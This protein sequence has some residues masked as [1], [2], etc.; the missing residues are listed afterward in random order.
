LSSDKTSGKGIIG[1]TLNG[2]TKKIDLN[3]TLQNG[4][5]LDAKTNLNLGD[6][7]ALSALDSLNKVC[8][9]LHKGKDG[10]SKLWPEVE[11]TI[12]TKLKLDCK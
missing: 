8:M 11:L 3:F 2:V 4:I 1:L 12:S 6:F 10:A 7:K 5:Q 9:D